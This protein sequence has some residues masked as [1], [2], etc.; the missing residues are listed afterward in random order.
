M[1]VMSIEMLT[2]ERVTELWPVLEPYFDAA[3]KGNEIAKDE[4]DVKDIYVLAVTGLVAVFVGFED[5]EPACVMGI[6]FNT[7]NGHKCADVIALAGRGLMRFKAAYWRIILEWL[8]AN[9]VEFLDAYAPERLAKI[10]MNRFGF[11]KS[12]MYVRMVLQGENHE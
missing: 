12:C 2:P 11:N 5:G 3:C 6:Q 8:K 10:Y 4:L 9:G 1:S 7:T